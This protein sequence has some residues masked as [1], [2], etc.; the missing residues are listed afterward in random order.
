VLQTLSGRIEAINELVRKGLL[1]HGSPVRVRRMLNPSIGFC[2]SRTP[3]NCHTGV[4]ATD[5][6]LIAYFCAI[7][8]NHPRGQ[9]SLSGWALDPDG[10]F[11]FYMSAP[12][13]QRL[14]RGYVYVLAPHGF[15]PIGEGQYISIMPV[16]PIGC[17]RV[18]PSAFPHRILPI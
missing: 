17:C 3:A 7:T 9:A 1:L 2:I 18:E 4:Y 5:Q 11:R 8:P 13:L 16:A 6:V 12:L 15:E 10:Q 14:K